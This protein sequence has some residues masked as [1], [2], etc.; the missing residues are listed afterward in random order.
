MDLRYPLK[1]IIYERLKQQK[2][3]VDL[4]LLNELRKEDS[5]ITMKDLNKALLSLE[6]MGLVSVRW[7]RKDA[8]R[9]EIIE[10]AS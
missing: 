7:V 1:N 10:K 3:V 4:D 9:V 5:N 2:N 8:R 6:I